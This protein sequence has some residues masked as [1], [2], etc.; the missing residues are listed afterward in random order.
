ME[1]DRTPLSRLQREFPGWGRGGQGVTGAWAVGPGLNLLV[2][3]RGD[4]LCMQHFKI[5]KNLLST[6]DW[7][8]QIVLG[9][10][11]PKVKFV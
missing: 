6:N 4:L 8:V 2:P 9:K 5:F 3:P 7:S 11:D 10:S 1:E